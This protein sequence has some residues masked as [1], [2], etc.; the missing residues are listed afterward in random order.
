ME[1]IRDKRVFAAARIDRRRRQGKPTFI[2]LH[3]DM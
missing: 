1:A 3:F 2:T